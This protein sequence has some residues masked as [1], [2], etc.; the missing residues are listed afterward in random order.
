MGHA[1]MHQSGESMHE[2][3]AGAMAIAGRSIVMAGITTLIAAECM[4][5][6]GPI[7][8]TFAAMF[9]AI[10]V[11]GLAGALLFV[12]VVLSFCT[13]VQPIVTLKSYRL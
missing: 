5:F 11:F 10:V 7:F 9:N 4:F 12:P 1:F 2:R 8:A 3:V 13:W 6:G